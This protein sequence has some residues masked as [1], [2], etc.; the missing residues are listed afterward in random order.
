[1]LTTMFFILFNSHSILS[2]TEG[3]GGEI[4]REGEQEER[5][6]IIVSFMERHFSTFRINFD[7]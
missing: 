2:R 1:M 4:R 7:V 5:Y 6:Q 3:G